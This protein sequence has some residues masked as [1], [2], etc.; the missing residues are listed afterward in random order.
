MS[1]QQLFDEHLDFVA[2]CILAEKNL[3]GKEQ[4]SFQAKALF[5]AFI[6]RLEPD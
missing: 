2:M 3:R 1:N 4:K 5:P 6:Y